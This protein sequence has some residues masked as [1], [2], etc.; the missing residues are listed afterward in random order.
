LLAQRVELLCLNCGSA[1][2]EQRAEQISEFPKCSTC[3]SG[4]LA[5]RTKVRADVAGIIQKWKSRHELREDERQALSQARR[6]ADLILSYGRQA[7]VALLT[8]GVGL[9]TAT[10]ILARMHTDEEDFYA[11]LLKAKLKYI[12]TRPFWDR[13]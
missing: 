10:S 7:V 12:Q 4:L 9:Q 11:D 6:T 1:K 13:T 8:W 2:P 5:L 3:G